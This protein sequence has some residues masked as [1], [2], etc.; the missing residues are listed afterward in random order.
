LDAVPV[1]VSAKTF[2]T[3]GNTRKGAP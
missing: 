3:Q 2:F 1:A